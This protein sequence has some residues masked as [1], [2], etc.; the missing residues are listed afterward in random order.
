VFFTMPCLGNDLAVVWPRVPPGCRVVAYGVVLIFNYA[1]PL[2]CVKLYSSVS[3]FGGTTSELLNG[4]L[5]YGYYTI[6]YM[7]L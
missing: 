5:N 1:L 6:T 2:K 7:F 3:E 4:F